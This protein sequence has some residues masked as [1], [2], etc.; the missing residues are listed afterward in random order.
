MKGYFISDDFSKCSGIG[1]YSTRLYEKMSEEHNIK[2]IVLDSSAGKLRVG[3]Q[4]VDESNFAT[5]RHPVLFGL[6]CRNELPDDGDVF[7]ISHPGISFLNCEP[8]V[9]TVHDL[10][11]YLYPRR[12]FTEYFTRELFYR[13]VRN[14]EH[15]ITCSESTRE[16][17][18]ELLNV[19][20]EIDVVYP[21]VDDIYEPQDID[22]Q[23]HRQKFGI[24]PNSN[25]LLFVGT[26]EPRKNFDTVLQVTARLRDA[27]DSVHLIKVGGSSK[28]GSRETSIEAA[29]EL[30]IRDN[31]TFLQDVPEAEMP[32]VYRM[33]DILLLPSSYEGF[34][35]PPLE[36][37]ACGT[38]VITSG[39]ASLPEVV[40]N[41]GIQLSP[42]AI[43]QWEEEA[44]GL[45]TD[46]ERYKSYC[47][48][49]LARAERF[50]WGTAA[51][52]VYDIYK[53]YE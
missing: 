36:A 4:T 13:P 51:E 5:F 2:K 42:T 19:S 28:F 40:G 20:G 30:G 52:K 24:P 49:G 9:V 39:R 53:K 43:D 11:K 35:F 45:L 50:D 31:V 1:N 44:K 48:Q 16:D 21:G 32:D 10:I 34:G 38:P 8:K 17:L 3:G 18:E 29:R 15:V 25:I 41:A 14:A 37:M 27:L 26:E 6:R 22:V 47:T 12:P 46:A 33:S 23:A 7:H